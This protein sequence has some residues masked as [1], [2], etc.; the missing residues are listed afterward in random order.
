MSIY[1]SFKT[2][3]SISIQEVE[4]T[5]SEK[6]SLKKMDNYFM[7]SGIMIFFSEE[8]SLDKNIIKDGFDFSPAI[9]I[10]FQ[11]NPKGLYKEGKSLLLS[12]CFYFLKEYGSDAVLLFNGEDVVFIRKNN[13]LILNENWNWEDYKPNK[14]NF[15]Y[16]IQPIKS[17][18][19]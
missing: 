9:D 13:D 3:L 18:L 10:T 12:I 6:F 17:P 15:S 19:I 4:K 8:S 1:F 5:I 11:I 14:T 7:G 2:S 16:K